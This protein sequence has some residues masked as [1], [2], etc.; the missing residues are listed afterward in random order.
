MKKTLLIMLVC[1]STASCNN[2]KELLTKNEWILFSETKADS[3]TGL[4]K[5]KYYN[6][7]QSP[8]RIKLNNDGSFIYTEN[9]MPKGVQILNKW[10]LDNDKLILHWQDAYINETNT[11]TITRLDSS[12]LNFTNENADGDLKPMFTFYPKGSA[13]E[14]IKTEFK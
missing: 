13:L 3:V 7:I 2:K 11:V 8:I 4:Y 6:F 10:E 5:T 9:D 1:I 14:K 12:F